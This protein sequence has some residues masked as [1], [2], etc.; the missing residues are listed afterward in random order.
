[1]KLHI[2]H[3]KKLLK[4]EP[5]LKDARHFFYSLS[6][7]VNIEIFWMDERRIDARVLNTLAEN[8]NVQNHLKYRTK[9][10]ASA[11]DM[12][13]FIVGLHDHLLGGSYS[14]PC[15]E[16]DLEDWIDM[17]RG[18]RGFKKYRESLLD[19]NT[20]RMP[21]LASYLKHEYLVGGLPFAEREYMEQG[22]YGRLLI[23][24]YV[25]FDPYQLGGRE[26]LLP[27]DIG[28]TKDGKIFFPMT[29]PSSNEIKNVTPNFLNRI[30]GVFD[31][32]CLNGKYY[33]PEYMEQLRDAAYVLLE[34]EASA[35]SHGIEHIRNYLNHFKEKMGV[36]HGNPSH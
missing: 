2:L 25:N 23:L 28:P 27:I 1:M 31:L 3:N 19:F 21:G 7:R 24:P 26:D 6:D 14:H 9:V 12:D 15:E 33:R 10:S 36:A 4:R 29:L 18:Q 8:L 11:R 32:E 35:K 22:L 5:F 34:A 20:N 13:N 30:R 17:Q 16:R